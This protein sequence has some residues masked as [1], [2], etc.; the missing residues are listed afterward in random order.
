MVTE[1]LDDDHCLACAITG[2]SDCLVTGDPRL[3]KLGTFKGIPILSPTDF[4]T[5][6]PPLALRPMSS[7]KRWQVTLN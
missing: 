6:F 3:L 4:L 5:R 2:G 7:L 1:D